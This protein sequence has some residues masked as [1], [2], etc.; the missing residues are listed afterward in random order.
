[1]KKIPSIKTIE[2]CENSSWDFGN[3]IL[4]NLC[5]EN[6]YHQDDQKI[7]SKVW[8]IGRAYSAAIERRKN[9]DTIND[10]FYIEKVVPK[11]KDRELDKY[12]Y[13]LKQYTNLTMDNL[14]LVLEA[15]N[16]LTQLT[17]SITDLEKRSF[18]SKYLH[19]HLP[20]LFF[21]Y[22][23]R[24]VDSLRQFISY[25]PKDLKFLMKSD[26]IDEEYS[27]FVCKCFAITKGIKDQHDIDISTR[28]FDNIMINIANYKLINNSTMKNTNEV[29]IGT[30]V[31]MAE[32]LNVS[33]FRNGDPI[34]E[35]KTDEEWEKAGEEGKPA[36]C[37]YDN[38][39]SN[40]TKY[41]KLYNWY[42]VNDPRGLAPNG[43]HI[44]TDAEW[45]QLSDYL[46]GE[47]EA[48]TKMK[49]TS[50]W[51]QN[52]GTNSSGLSCLPGGYRSNSGAF[53]FIDDKGYWWSCSAGKYNDGAWDRYLGYFDSDVSRSYNR[54]T[55]GFSVRC[56]RD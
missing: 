15:H 17:A 49:S 33:T 46:G 25:V 42:A 20:K 53:D 44:P 56:L 3:S 31:W 18:S 36:W 38:D 16:Y 40:G 4:Y 13:K 52:N 23:S 1:M 55:Y 37:Y 10:N 6:F 29:T 47:S 22:D 41:G 27:K 19:F 45:T 9:K 11:F 43:Y 12:L 54:M 50:G 21:I 2:K 32:N 28:V 48:G 7:L 5:Q 34:P 8:L 24:V 35:A 26:Q 39:A 14:P 30:Q 51:A